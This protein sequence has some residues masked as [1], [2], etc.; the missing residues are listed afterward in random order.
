[1]S[2]PVE[3]ENATREGRLSIVFCA[4]AALVS[5]S[6]TGSEHDLPDVDGS[7]FAWCSEC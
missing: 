4:A 3:G 2:N 6:A 5:G 1:M 7:A